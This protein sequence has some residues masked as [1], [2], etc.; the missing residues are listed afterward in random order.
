MNITTE[1]AIDISES[2]ASFLL[3]S[4]LYHTVEANPV[5]ERRMKHVDTAKYTIADVYLPKKNTGFEVKSIEHGT[6]ALK[7]VLQ[8]S[9]YLEEVDKSLLVMQKP[10]RRN[11]VKAIES[12]S[13]SHNIGVMWII[14]IPNILDEDTVKRA[15][16]GCAKPFE[17]WRQRDYQ[18][19]KRAIIAKSK[20]GW[21]QEYIETLE[22]IVEEKSDQI[23][24]YSVKPSPC[25]RGFSEIY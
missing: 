19:T 8:S 10:R 9:I 21:A 22:Q 3:A 18:S 24:E 20:S 4:H 5:F 16:G 14:G 7:G 15:T 6:A 1:S 25:G 2:L 13:D 17:L 12:M 11:L 23:F